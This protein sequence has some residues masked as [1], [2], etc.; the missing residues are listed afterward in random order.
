MCIK[1]GVVIENALNTAPNPPSLVVKNLSTNGI[2]I[3]GNDHMARGVVIGKGVHDAAWSL[4][5]APETLPAARALPN[6]YPCAFNATCFSQRSAS[7]PLM[8]VNPT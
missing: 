1:R 4:W 7:T 6:P 2:K 5:Y 3:L 8:P